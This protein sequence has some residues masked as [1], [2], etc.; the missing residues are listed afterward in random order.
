MRENRAKQWVAR[1]FNDIFI[2][3]RR[4]WQGIT[5]AFAG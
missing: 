5:F 3:K 2:E 4:I 1:F